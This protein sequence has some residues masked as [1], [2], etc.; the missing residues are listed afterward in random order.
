[1]DVNFLCGEGGLLERRGMDTQT[2]DQELEISAVNA[3]KEN[4]A[5]RLLSIIEPQ[6][7]HSFRDEIDTVYIVIEADGSKRILKVDK[8][9]SQF[10]EWCSDNYHTV[11]NEILPQGAINNVKRLVQSRATDTATLYNRVAHIGDRLYY[12]LADKRC[13][14]VEI[15][16]KGWK[17]IENPCI[18]RTAQAQVEPIHHNN[19]TRYLKDIFSKCS[20]VYPYQKLIAEVYTI[21]LF[22]PNIMHSMIIPNGPVGVGKTTILELIGLIVDPHGSNN[23][24]FLKELPKEE[25]D[26]RVSIYSDYL[27]YFDNETH[28]SVEV[29]DNF[30]RW[31]TGYSWTGRSLW[32]DNKQISYS[33]MRPPFLWT[34]GTL[35]VQRVRLGASSVLTELKMFSSIRSLLFVN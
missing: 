20:I 3:K 33:G 17:I 1:M 28:I 7:K 5:E 26:R 11:E 23:D 4:T 21:S 25:K 27:S 30:C 14:A 9:E 12:N 13:R 15:T 32:T 24:T 6:I 18:F 34:L 22:I 31:V 2:D 35:E 8:K 16:A 19:T 10:G 29:M